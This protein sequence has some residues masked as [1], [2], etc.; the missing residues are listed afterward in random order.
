MSEHIEHIYP[1]DIQP[2]AVRAGLDW[3][4]LELPARPLPMMPNG[5]GYVRNILMRLGYSVQQL[6]ANIILYHRH[7]SRRL[8]GGI[9]PVVSAEGR[10]MAPDPWDGATIDEMNRPEVIEFF[11]PD[12]EEIVEKIAAA[13]PQ[14]VA[15]S[16]NGHNLQVG[17]F[18]VQA[19]RR[20]R[21]EVVIV[22]CGSGC[23][24]PHIGTE[25]FDDYDYMV[26][27]EAEMSL[28][29]LAEAI[30]AGRR[31][32][33]L[34]GILSMYDP[35]GRAFKPAPLPRDLDAAGFPRYEDM[36]LSM[37]RTYDNR[38]LV[39]IA[40]SRGCAWG[41]CRSCGEAVPY[42]KRRPEMVVDEIQFL[43]GRGFRVFQ[44]NDRGI[45][46]DPQNLR[47]IADG[48][49][50]R[51][52]DV[53]LTGRMRV[54]RHNTPEYMRRLRRAGF[55]R[56]RFGVDGWS[57]H[58]LR[59]LRK[60]YT[61]RQVAESLRNSHD[62]G[63]TTTVSVVVGVPG[64]TEEDVDETIANIIRLKPHID[65]VESCCA[66]IL[67][68]GSSY[69]LHPGKYDIH[70]RDDPKR[71]Y[72]ANRLR[73][74]PELWYSEGPYIDHPVRMERLRRVWRALHDHGVPIAPSV[75]ETLREPEPAGASPP[76]RIEL[77]ETTG[78]YNIVRVD[79]DHVG[80]A[81]SLGPTD[82]AA[83]RLGDRD[84]WPYVLRADSRDGAARAV[85]D[86]GGGEGEYVIHEHAGGAVAIH[87]GLGDVQP[88]AAFLARLDLPPYVYQGQTPEDIRRRL[89]PAPG[90]D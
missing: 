48:I 18:V 69:Y 24:Y 47:A 81:R 78:A 79:D 44:F 28:P 70:F 65:L 26:I 71:I 59:L 51:G 12:L 83:E 45:N 6:D 54:D 84:L 68:A 42:R 53:K 16:L 89:D 21:P 60:G 31:P 43:N 66:L 58:T 87:R 22:A 13:A 63:I 74:P 27:G 3:L 72:A 34:P 19:L 25:L 4:V 36:D 85:A 35:P 49:I 5:T 77:V 61:M 56:L 20:R 2:V 90:G 1:I 30:R 64:E 38:H 9:P 52:L 55:V 15:I 17:R 50:Q 67:A 11:R 80:I 88:G 39:P 7:H 10:P 75:E 33:G 86:H 46:G 57:R 76:R 29:D 32:G 73:V 62:A 41:R 37:Y 82:L 14:V 40:A 23:L 8:S